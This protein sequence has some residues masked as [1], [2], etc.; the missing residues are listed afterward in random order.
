MPNFSLKFVEL[1]DGAQQGRVMGHLDSLLILKSSLY[2]QVLSRFQVITL[3]F[4]RIIGKST[5]CLL[6]LLYVRQPV[7]ADSINKNVS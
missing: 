7:D 6:T 1:V 3:L 2:L 5:T 4:A